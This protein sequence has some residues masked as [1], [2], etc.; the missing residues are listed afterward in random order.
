[1]SYRIREATPGDLG[2]IRPLLPR[3]AAFDLPERRAP[4]D[5]WRGDEEMLLKWQEGQEPH[6]TAHVAVD[7]GDAILGI[8]VMRLRPELLSSEPSAHLEVL[9]VAEGAEGQGIG[10]ALV[11]EA[12][13]AARASGARTMTLHVFGVNR[14]ARG[15]YEKLGYDGE[16]VRY[17][18]DLDG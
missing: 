7:G 9:A 18:K 12:E 17:I 11:G 5:L 4:E 8:S 10:K 14:R 3:L 16:L 2:A 1:M 6:L 15:M 13:K